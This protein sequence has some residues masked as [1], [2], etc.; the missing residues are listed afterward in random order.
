MEKL[1]ITEERFEPKKLPEEESHYVEMENTFEATFAIDKCMAYRACDELPMKQAKE[2]KNR[3]VFTALK[4][5]ESWF[6]N[7][8]FSYGPY[9]EVLGPPEVRKE[10]KKELMRCITDII[11]K[12]VE[13]IK[14]GQKNRRSSH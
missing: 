10:M 14:A 13:I 5:H 8:I 6:Y 3:F 11:M 7:Y 9:A 1:V 2:E 12:P 4:A